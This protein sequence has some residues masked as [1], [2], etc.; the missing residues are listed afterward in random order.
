MN[1]RHRP[2]TLYKF[3]QKQFLEYRESG[4]VVEF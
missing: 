4:S 1:V 3:D 2:S